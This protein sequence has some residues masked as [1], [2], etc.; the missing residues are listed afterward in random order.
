MTQRQ[1]TG[2][3]RSSLT[4]EQVQLKE[5][6]EAIAA[7]HKR[8]KQNQRSF[9]R[10]K[11]CSTGQVRSAKA[12]TIPASPQLVTK[13]LHGEKVV[14]S[15]SPINNGPKVPY[16]PTALTI[17][18]EPKLRT[19]ARGRRASIHGEVSAQPELPLAEAIYKMEHSVPNRFHEKAKEQPKTSFTGKLTVPNSP[20]LHQTQK[21]KPVTKSFQEQED[22]IIEEGRKHQFKAR[23]LNQKIVEYGGTFG[24]PKITSRAT[25]VPEAFTFGTTHRPSTAGAPSKDAQRPKSLTVPQ[26][27][28]L[29]TAQRPRTAPVATG[30]DDPENQENVPPEKTMRRRS[31]FTGTLT[32]TKP[33]NLSTESR[34]AMHAEK[35]RRHESAKSIKEFHARQMPNFRN[36]PDFVPQVSEKPLTEFETFN[37]QSVERHQRKVAEIQQRLAQLKG[38]QKTFHARPLP[39]SS[40]SPDDAFVVE[41]DTN[42]APLQPREVNLASS[43]RAV[44]RKEFDKANA[45]RVAKAESTKKKMLKARVR[46]EEKKILTLRRRSIEQGGMAFKAKAINE[47]QIKKA[48]KPQTSKRELTVPVTPELA[49]M[50][51]SQFRKAI[52]G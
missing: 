46:E 12:L 18:S 31:S 33:F 26:S 49:T 37:L 5:A 17:P 7:Q 11:V 44:A 16:D 20:K 36:G 8:V 4:T 29:Y 32:E 27:P 13:Q 28:H 34:G 10:S 45:R 39:R 3:L 30:A 35:Q 48:F 52:E 42:R 40:I 19:M 1:S 51:R 41:Y 50:A 47:K 38:N 6:A 2:S 15:P 24:V 23:P 22:E 21:S 14:Q 9:A 25:T 43:I